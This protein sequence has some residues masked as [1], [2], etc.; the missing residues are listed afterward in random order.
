MTASSPPS[1][2]TVPTASDL[3]GALV[4]LAFVAFMLAAVVLVARRVVPFLRAV[5]ALR[6]L[7]ER[8][9][10][11]NGGDSLKDQ[12][13]RAREEATR[14]RAAAES[15]QQETVAARAEAR[16]AQEAAERAH[17]KLGARAQRAVDDHERRHHAAE[18]SSSSSGSSSERGS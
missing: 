6:K 9:L 13:R 18:R 11:P 8:E 10:Q 1:I 14:A 16:A 2:P 7:A 12:A 4:L 5:D 17:A 15:T 3:E